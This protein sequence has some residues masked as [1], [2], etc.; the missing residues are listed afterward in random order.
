[1]IG[2]ITPSGFVTGYDLN[3]KIKAGL[4][5]LGTIVLGADGNIWFAG[6]NIIGKITPNGNI[7]Y[8]G[9]GILNGDIQSMTAGPDGN[10]LFAQIGSIGK[11]APDG[12]IEVLNIEIP[13]GTEFSSITTGPDKS[14]W[15]M[16]AGSDRI[17]KISRSG[18]VKSYGTGF[19]RN[20]MESSGGIVAGSDT[21]LWFA[22]ANE[23]SG[24]L[25]K[26]SVSGKLETI[27]L[28]RESWLWGIVAGP[29]GNIWFTD[30]GRRLIGKVS[31]N[32][33]VEEFNGIG[34]PANA[35]EGPIINRYVAGI[36]VGPDNNLWFA[37]PAA[38]KIGRISTDAKNIDTNA[39]LTTKDLVANFKKPTTEIDL[40]RNIKEIADKHLLLRKDFYSVENFS[41][42]FGATEKPTGFGDTKSFQITN[43]FSHAKSKGKEND[44]AFIEL[45]YGD[46]IG[47]DQLVKVL[48]KSY[49]RLSIAFGDHSR[50]P[51]LSEIEEVFGKNWDPVLVFPESH[52]PEK[53]T[54]H[55][56]HTKI[57]RN[58][59]VASYRF[60]NGLVM[61][62]IELSF[63]SSGRL[64]KLN[65]LE[66]Q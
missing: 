34:V 21:N 12:A 38:G 16:E 37:E 2:K 33:V 45:A 14:I 9:D 49:G 28:A 62:Y 18:I 19:S 55:F 64:E 27:D 23:G 5:R 10:I 17:L 60:D 1:M 40:V 53:S 41:P 22:T 58:S 39:G 32:R 57:D 66:K 35:A 54:K 8:Y 26:I 47:D 29:D 20:P 3:P 56:G 48:S 36:T 63:S 25:G 65:Y 31:S 11:I 24:Q 43:S 42:V 50:T 52:L 4:G 15:A 46:N 13:H 7:S 51:T 6:R 59:T 44:F 30:P 61:D